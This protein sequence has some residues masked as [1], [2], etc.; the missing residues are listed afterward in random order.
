MLNDNRK[1]WRRHSLVFVEHMAR[2]NKGAWL[3][4][5]FDRLALRYCRSARNIRSRIS[6]LVERQ[7][8][9]RK[10]ASSS[11]DRSGGRI[12]FSRA[13]FVC[14]LLPGVR[15]I[16]ALP[17]WHAQDAGHSARSASGRLHQNM[18]TPL[19]ERSRSRLTM[20]SRQSVGTYQGN[21]LTHSSSLNTR[22]QSSQLAEPPWTDP[23]LEGLRWCARADLH[24][25]KKKKCRRGMW[26]EP[27]WPSGKALGW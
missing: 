11:L 17:Q 10:V 22:H 20:L 15:S 8:R 21:E 25:L 3:L 2:H 26:R 18:R 16:S 6:L 12:F 9:D 24:L 14:W 7:I 5:K 19:T 1:H 4:W 27:V 23:G 13:N